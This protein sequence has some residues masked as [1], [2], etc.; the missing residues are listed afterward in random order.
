MAADGFFPVPSGPMTL[1]VGDAEAPLTYASMVEQYAQLTEQHVVMD[2]DTGSLL[3]QRILLDRTLVVP[4]GEVQLTF[5]QVLRQGDFALRSLKH[6]GARLIE[7]LSLKTQIRN[8]L[9]SQA[10]ALK[11]EELGVAKEHPAL[12]FSTVVALPNVD[13]RQMSNS[14]R[15]MISNV[16]TL[17]VLHVGNANNLLILGFG[18][19]LTGLAELFRTID[20]ASA[21]HAQR[22]QRSTEVIRLEH[23]TAAELVPLLNGLYGVKAGQRQRHQPTFLADS[24]TNTLVVDT[25]AERLPEVKD[26]IAALDIE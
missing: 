3:S 23:A 21:K 13:A 20:T 1:T 22:F 6:E 25:F 10:I 11:P 17:Q 26:L 18:D 24:R 19:N 15:T 4:A 8:T 16:N 14:V 12:F 5:E 9:R 7:V 2:A